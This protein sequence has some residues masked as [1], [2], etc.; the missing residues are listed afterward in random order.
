MS[1]PLRRSLERR[2]YRLRELENNPAARAVELELCR[3]SVQYWFDNWTWTYDPRSASLGGAA[4][5]PFI[6]NDRQREFVA[7]LED[8]ERFQEDGGC[9]KSRDTGFTWMCSGFAVHRWRFRSGYKTK[10]GSRK[11]EYVDKLGDPDCIFEKIRILVKMMP[12]W[13]LPV[14]GY[15]SKHEL[16]VNLDNHNTIGGEGGDEMGRGG[17]S[18]MYIVDEGAFLENADR[19]E[20]ATSQTSDVRIWGSS[21]NG[22]G[23]LFYRKMHGGLSPRQ[24]FRLHYTTDPRWTPERVARKKAD[25][26]SHVWA[27][28]MEIDYAVSVEGICIPATWVQ[29]AQRLASLAPGLHP[30]VEGTAGGDVGAGKARSVVVSRFGPVVLPPVSWTDPDTI[31]TAHRMLDAVSAIKLRRPDNWECRVTRLNYDSVGV[32]HGIT[33][34]MTRNPLPGLQVCGVNVGE[35]P[36]DKMWPDGKEAREKFAN[37]KAELMW[38]VRDRFKCT[39]EMVLWLEKQ[40]GGREHPLEDCISLPPETAGPDAQMLAS[41]VALVRWGRNEKGKIIIESK[42]ALAKRGIRSPDHLE[43]LVLSFSDR[44]EAAGWAAF[45]KVMGAAA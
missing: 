8:R 15:D 29:A 13:M 45:G 42:E 12:A 44:S 2:L 23:N 28:E 17:R 39:H 25:T 36:S 27:S 43:G 7:W 26:E 21:A 41:Q 14:S 32:G 19:V 33:A 20:A 22:P 40:D 1:T 24:R 31:E 5:V 35:T 16:M 3:R 37:Y 4:L 18:T 11:V 38:T 9:E 34:V 10:F 30:A 6:L